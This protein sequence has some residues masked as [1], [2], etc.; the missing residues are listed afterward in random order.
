MIYDRPVL[1]GLSITGR[2]LFCGAKMGQ[3]GAL[4]TIYPYNQKDPQTLDF[5]GVR[6]SFGIPTGI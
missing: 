4:P 6:G 3:N 2:P 1:Q 5:T